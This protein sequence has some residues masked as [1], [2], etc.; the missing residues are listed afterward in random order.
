MANHNM[1]FNGQITHRSSS[2]E[3]IFLVTECR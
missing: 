1:F 2:Q 3:S